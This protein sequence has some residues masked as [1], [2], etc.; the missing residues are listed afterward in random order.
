MTQKI[1][2]WFKDIVGQSKAISRTSM[3]LRPYERTHYFPSSLFVGPRGYGKTTFCKAIGKNLY[4]FNDSGDMIK[5]GTKP[6][7]KP[8]Y[9]IN[10]AMVKT[11]TNFIE[12]PLLHQI[13]DKDITVLFDECHNMNHN[14][15]QAMLDVIEP[16][17]KRTELRTASGLVFNFDFTRQ[18]FLFA[19][20]EPQHLFHA[21][22]SRL[23]R[24][25]L[26][27]YSDSEMGEILR[28]EIRKANDKLSVTDA[29]VKEIVPTLR[30]EPRQAE[31]MA[32]DIDTFLNGRTTLTPK[33][34]DGVKKTLGIFPEGL[35]DTEVRVLRYLNG[36][37]G[38]LTPL[39][40]L[41]SALS[42]T[43]D[44]LSKDFERYLQKRGFMEIEKGGR[45]ITQLG[46]A[47]VDFL[48]GKKRVTNFR[49]ANVAS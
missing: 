47:Y 43:E 22:V 40:R 7:H 31:H 35:N 48:D 5:S 46:R 8:F 17:A 18:T 19:T 4:Q 33:D 10:C 26:E 9:K 44:A 21:F 28:R 36:R 14:W 37:G 27:E 30:G 32:R 49:S 39:R 29:L 20:T 12:G 13:H 24:I 23:L 11:L 2:D 6:V 41:G 42:L 45:A 16:N 1:N 34:W 38:R 3:Y 25:D 15:Q